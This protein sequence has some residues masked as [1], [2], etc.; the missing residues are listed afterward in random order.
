MSYYYP[1]RIIPKPDTAV[2]HERTKPTV[3]FGFQP[4]SGIDW[5]PAGP[6]RRVRDEATVEWAKGMRDRP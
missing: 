5:Q 6:E 3:P 4:G 1:W 2:V